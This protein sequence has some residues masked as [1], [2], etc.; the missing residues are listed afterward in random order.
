MRSIAM[1]VVVIVG[2]VT[3]TDAQRGRGGAPAAGPR[4]GTLEHITVGGRAADVYLPAT[5]ASDAMRRFPVVYF[6]AETP[7]DS[8]REAAGKVAAAPGFS[9]PIVVMT[10]IS[11]ASGE[12]EKPADELVAYV[13]GHYRTITA[14]ISRGLAGYSL[15]GDGALRVAM[16]RPEVFSSLY[17]LSPSP[18]EATLAMIDGAAANLQR[19]YGIA[20]NV[21][22][23][24]PALA[25]N[26]RL[27]D[28]MMRSRIPHYYEEFDGTLAD[29]AAERIETR[30]LPFFS[31]NLTAPANP[32]SPAVQ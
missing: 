4:N 10:A 30:V 24:D 14:R 12:P 16:K 5:Y 15:A 25:M 17:L 29:R 23:A 26:R 32:T 21:G 9:D 22:V 31:R 3:T 27:H 19:F 1:G 28:V 8:V 6:F 11:S 13:D 18:V 2:M 20:I 7:V